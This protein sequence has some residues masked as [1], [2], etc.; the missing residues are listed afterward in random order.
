MNLNDFLT[1]IVKEKLAGASV[2][3]S[4][5]ADMVASLA[6]RLNKFITLNV[7]TELATKD[8][9]L[10]VKFQELTKGNTT[11]DV[12]QTFIENE[13]PDGAAILAKVLSDFR[14]LYVGK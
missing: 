2:G 8:Q 9:A 1:T 11:P 7:L 3:E 4:Q 6:V 13:I 10:L 14:T 12:I 5:I